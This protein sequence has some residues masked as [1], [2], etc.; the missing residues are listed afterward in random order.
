MLWPWIFLGGDDMRYTYVN[1]TDYRSDNISAGVKYQLQAIHR[2][3][4]YHYNDTLDML[5]ISK[6]PAMTTVRVRMS[7]SITRDLV[8]LFYLEGR[9]DMVV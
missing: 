6:D 9:G 8:F 3:L 1:S 2:T 4:T 7:S 5:V